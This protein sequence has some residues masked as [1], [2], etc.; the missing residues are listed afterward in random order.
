[1][2]SFKA[3]RKRAELVILFSW[4]AMGLQALL[5]ISTTLQLLSPGNE[6]PL[7][8]TA[9]TLNNPG[10]VFVILLQALVLL[11][12]VA[13]NITW[14]IL[15]MMWFYRAYANL[16]TRLPYRLSYSPGM[17]VGFFFIPILNLFRPFQT[18]KELYDDTRELFERDGLSDPTVLSTGLV[19]WWWT[20]WIVSFIM[21][22][23][24]LRIAPGDLKTV[25]GQ[26]P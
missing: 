10:E 14:R 20:V 19:G 18:M 13:A 25:S 16:Q 22:F 2:K 9:P 24:F 5:F 8:N 7:G 11:L 17:A 15:L 1:M 12:S 21:S 4:I 23:V 3:N 6:T 26:S